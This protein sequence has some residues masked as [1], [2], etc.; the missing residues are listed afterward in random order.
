MWLCF[1]FSNLQSHPI[2]FFTVPHIKYHDSVISRKFTV[3]RRLSSISHYNNL[4]VCNYDK[5]N[6]FSNDFNNNGIL[7]IMYIHAGLKFFSNKD[8]DSFHIKLIESQL[9]LSFVK[10]SSKGHS[11]VYNLPTGR[12]LGLMVIGDPELFNDSIKSHN[13]WSCGPIVYKII[14]TLTLTAVAGQLAGQFR[15]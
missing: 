13:D 7:K 9:Q 6:S 11:S 10:D 15:N 3:L 2:K 1:D 4:Q 8:G 14:E 12:I 5:F